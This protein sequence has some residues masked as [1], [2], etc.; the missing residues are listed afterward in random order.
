MF[1]NSGI[2]RSLKNRMAEAS[3][4]QKN[5][6]N[7]IYTNCKTSKGECNQQNERDR[8]TQRIKARMFS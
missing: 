6:D 7:V 3:A 1:Y 2:R 8:K 4:Q 5:E